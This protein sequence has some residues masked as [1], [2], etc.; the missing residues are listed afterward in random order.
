MDGQRAQRCHK[1]FIPWR[2]ASR[3]RARPMSGW[4]ARRMK[5]RCSSTRRSGCTSC[6]TAWVDTSAGRSRR[7][8]PLPPSARS[9][10]RPTTP[11]AD[12]PDKL[13]DGDSA[14]P[15]RPSSRKAKAD[16][17]LHNMGT[18]VVG[19]SP[20]RRS[21][22]PRA[23]RRLAHLPP[24]AGQVRAGHARPLAHQPLRGQ[25]RA[26]GALRPAQLERHRARRRAARSGR[27][28]SSRH[29]HGAGRHVPALLRRADRHGRR[30]DAQ[31]DAR[32]RRRRARSTRR[33]TR[34]CAPRCPTAASTTPPSSCS[35]STSR[36]SR[37][38]SVASASA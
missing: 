36:R 27:G 29:R 32:R 18:T 26:G 1:I 5:T 21:P 12:D 17:S 37:G 24:A 25:P 15:T 6:A 28:R 7:S 8:S 14:R 16:P 9:F 35:G 30:L 13:V 34:W 10:A 22:A 31:G 2:C 23:R 3:A 33:A 38:G 19:H 20:G 11:P 4:F